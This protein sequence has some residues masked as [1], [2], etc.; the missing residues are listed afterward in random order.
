MTTHD[1]DMAFELVDRLGHAYALLA[2]ATAEIAEEQGVTSAEVIALIVL[3]SMDAPLSQSDWGRL[4]GVTRQRAHV[5]ANSLVEKG[6]VDR[7]RTGREARVTLTAAGRRE[8]RSLRASIGRVASR[9]LG[10]LRANQASQL[11]ALLGTLVD[12]LEANRIPRTD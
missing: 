5:V 4:Q 11:H 8:A 9:R 3:A 10:S 2:E 12:A 7:A 6:L 1:P